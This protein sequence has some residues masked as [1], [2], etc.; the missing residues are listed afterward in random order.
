MAAKGR[1]AAAVLGTAAGLAAPL[2]AYYEGTH[3]TTYR[4]PVGILTAC[5]GHTGAD[6]RPGVTHTPAQCAQWLDEDMREAATG[7]ERCIGV[8]LTTPQVA[9]LISFTFNVGVG[10]LCGS[11]LARLANAGAPPAVWC[12]QLLR[13]TKARKAGVLIELPGLVKRRQAEWRMCMGQVDGA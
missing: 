10:A 9:A 4:D 7:V 8:E 2:I 1:I 12:Q 3:P 6:V 5:T 11:T 13:W